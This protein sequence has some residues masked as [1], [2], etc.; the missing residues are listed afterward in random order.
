MKKLLLTAFASVLILPS[1]AASSQMAG[2]YPKGGADM[3]VEDVSLIQLIANPQAFDNKRVRIIG[4]LRLEFE[5]DVIYFHRE[6]YEYGLTKNGLW[7]NVPPDMTQAQKQAVNNKYVICTGIFRAGMHGH[8][9]L[10]S[11]E[12]TEITRLEPWADRPMRG[13]PPPPQ[14]PPAH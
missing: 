11:G 1:Q 14:P 9:G 4:Y 10:N 5:G 2:Y 8:M 12:L 7:V 6:D 13:L 3:G